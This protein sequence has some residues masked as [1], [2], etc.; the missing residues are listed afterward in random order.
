ME[1]LRNGGRTYDLL[2]SWNRQCA[3]SEEDDDDEEN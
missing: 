1:R 3:G 2:G